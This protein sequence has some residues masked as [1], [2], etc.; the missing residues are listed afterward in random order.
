LATAN[1]NT[2]SLR[3]ASRTNGGGASTSAARSTKSRT[4]RVLPATNNENYCWSHGYQIHADHTSMTCTRRAEGNQELAIKANNMGGRQWRCSMTIRGSQ[5]TRQTNY[6]LQ[7]LF[8]YTGCTHTHKHIAIIYS[9][10]TGHYLMMTAPVANKKVATTPIQVTLP[11]GAS[12][13]S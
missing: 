5:H 13:K 4:A 10:C 1:K 3:S 8:P 7:S 2:R 9:G 6:K 11:D 12:I